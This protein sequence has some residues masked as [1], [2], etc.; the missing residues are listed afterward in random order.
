MR[1]AILFSGRG[2][3]LG[4]LARAA[5][6]PEYPAEFV[7][8]LTNRPNAPG[9][10]IARE[11]GIPVRVVS[12]EAHEDREAHEAEVTAA[13]AEAGVQ[14]VCLAGYMRILS[15]EFV[16]RWRG[17]CVNIHPSLL[18]AFRGVDTHA[19]A[20]ER[21]VRVHGCS[22]HYVTS[23]LDGGPIVAQAAVPVLPGDDE[24]AL[25]ARVLEAEHA[26][27]PHCV[28]MIA[29]GTVRWSGDRVVA[30]PGTP[31]EALAWGLG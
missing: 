23:E 11:H 15:D 31:P 17:K 12:S 4:A 25:A 19:R 8:A 5:I 3:N 21:G 13:L 30:A 1:T 9:L 10:D 14:L 18:P 7:L 29:E 24:E 20:L 27:Y 28:A 26:L 16:R 2:S 22:V 6:D